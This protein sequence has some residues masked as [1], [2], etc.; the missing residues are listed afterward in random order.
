MVY[1]LV[2]EVPF[3]GHP[4]PMMN[5]CFTKVTNPTKERGYYCH[6]KW[7]YFSSSNIESS[8]SISLWPIHLNRLGL[9][10][11]YC[12]SQNL[13][14]VTNMI[15]SVYLHTRSSL[16][17]PCR[18]PLGGSHNSRHHGKCNSTISAFPHNVM[19]LRIAFLCV[20][21]SSFV[22]FCCCVVH[23][24]SI[25]SFRIAFVCLSVFR[26]CVVESLEVC[27]TCTLGF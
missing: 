1:K 5:S 24:G 17:L 26:V 9:D 6:C 20:F 2:S 14:L 4:W 12:S 10:Y 7:V 23:S 15:F 8:P 21:I 18:C 3:S 13:I 16:S 19:W 27:V 22:N 11:H 25:S